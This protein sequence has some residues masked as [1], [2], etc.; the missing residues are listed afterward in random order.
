MPWAYVWYSFLAEIVGTFIFVLF[1][2]VACTSDTTF[3]NGTIQVYVFIPTILMLAREYSYR[4]Q[5][6]NPAFA[7]AFEFFYTAKFNQWYLWKYVWATFFGPFVGSAIAVL[8][9]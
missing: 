2:I 1:I 3:C 7:I 4:S 6:L 9:F 8:F 5:G